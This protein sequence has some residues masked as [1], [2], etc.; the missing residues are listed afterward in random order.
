[1][2]FRSVLQ[3]LMARGLH[4]DPSGGDRPVLIPIVDPTAATAA[5]A[6]GERALVELEVG[7]SFDAARSR[8]VRLQARVEH[9]SDGQLTWAGA[10]YTGL[11]MVAGP[12][13]VLAAGALRV[14][15]VSAP[16][17]MADPVVFRG[18]GLEPAK[19]QAVVVKS[20]S[21]WRA[22]YGNLAQHSVLLDSPGAAS[23]N[24]RQFERRHSPRPLYPYDDFN[25][26][27]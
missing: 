27:P 14:L 18:N 11:G 20:P 3:T 8:P 9:L 23:A 2:L 6:A 22:L 5:H 19:A 25:W 7:G 12:T 1:M 4:E 10:A 26:E 17:P 24:I 15:V 13:A 16:V 21:N